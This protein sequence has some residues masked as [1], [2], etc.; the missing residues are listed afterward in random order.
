MSN[1]K[2]SLFNKGIIEERIK[3]ITFSKESIEK[4]NK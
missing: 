1:N 4:L 3:K 2:N